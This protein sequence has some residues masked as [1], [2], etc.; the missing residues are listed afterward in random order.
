MT[1]HV[2]PRRVKM[3]ATT[4]PPRLPTAM[5]RCSISLRAGRTR[6]GPRKMV[7]ASAKS[8]LCYSIVARRLVSSQSKSRMEIPFCPNRLVCHDHLNT[9]FEY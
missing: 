9:I 1:R 8:M 2:S 6:C 7:T 5:R 3:T 4:D